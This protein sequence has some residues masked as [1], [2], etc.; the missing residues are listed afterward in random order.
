MLTHKNNEILKEISR[1][2][3]WEIWEKEWNCVSHQTTETKRTGNSWITIKTFLLTV[4][5]NNNFFFCFRFSMRFLWFIRS[6]EVRKIERINKIESIK[7]K[8]FN[9]FIL[10][11]DS[12]ELK[13]VQCSF[14]FTHSLY[15]FCRSLG[16]FFLFFLCWYKRCRQRSIKWSRAHII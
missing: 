7:M 12:V 16:I 9:E 2:K 14:E 8:N 6:E 11:R 10:S 5:F 1:Y 3:S 4:P 13:F 15:F